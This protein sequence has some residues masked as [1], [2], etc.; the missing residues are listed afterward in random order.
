MS[1]KRL[2]IS[3]GDPAGCGPVITAGAIQDLRVPGVDLI[4]VGDKKVFLSLPSCKKFFKKVTFVDVGT[5]QIGV[6][7]KGEASRLSGQAALN[8]INRSLDIISGKR[9]ALVTAPVSKEAICLVHKDF[10]GHTEYLS[11]F[12]KSKN[13]AMMM[14]SPSFKT[15]LFSRH[16]PLS[17]VSGQ[18]KEEALLRAFKL[19]YQELKNKF[20]LPNPCVACASLNPHAGMNTFL[21]REEKI[22]LEAI[23][24]CPYPMQGPLSADTIFV[25]ESLKKYDCVIS[26]YHDQG[27]IPFKLLA[28]K[29]GVNLTL[30]LPIIRTSPAHGVAYD[31]IRQGKAPFYSS[32]LEAMKLAI[33]L[34]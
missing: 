26:L 25:K 22:I 2:V 28:M 23:K 33:R 19:I 4:V 8:Y 10:S 3:S 5:A 30:G 20:N 1:R 34:L 18:I 31:V 24:K 15:V 32:M 7:K 17:K 11:N 27:M 16:I 6:L 13:V 12:F 21:G 14:V 9:A 29:K